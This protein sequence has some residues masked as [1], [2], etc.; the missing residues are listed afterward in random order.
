[1]FLDSQD[2]LKLEKN[3][4][5]VFY[6]CVHSEISDNV[7]TYTVFKV[8]KIYFELYWIEL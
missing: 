2:I 5:F 8:T 7:L 6:N 3:H 1:M 4:V